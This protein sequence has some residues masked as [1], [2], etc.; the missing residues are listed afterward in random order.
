MSPEKDNAVKRFEES[1][2]SMASFLKTVML[3]SLFVSLLLAVAISIYTVRG[4][5]VSLQKGAEFSALMAKGDFTRRI[6]VTTK[7]EIGIL[8]ASLDVAGQNL[9]NLIRQVVNI[10]DQ[11]AASAEQLNVTADQSAQVVNQMASSVEEM[12]QGAEDQVRSVN[13]AAG[14][15]EEMSSGIHKIASH[16]NIVTEEAGRTSDVAKNGGQ[17]INTAVSQMT[18]IEHTVASSAAVVIK[19]GDRSKEINQIVDTIAGIAGQTNLLALNAAIEAARAGE[20]GRGFAVVAEEVRKLAEQSREAAGKIASLIGEIQGE[21]D[22]AVAAM[23]EGS[24][25]VKVGTEVVN[26][27]GKAFVEIIGAIEHMVGQIRE[28]S[29]AISQMAIG[30]GQIVASVKDINRV[31]KV[32]AAQTQAVLAA[33]E[34]ETASTEELASSSEALA[35][36][37]QDLQIAISRFKISQT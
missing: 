10:S 32:I 8:L 36:L 28:I 14:I 9:C 1:F 26:A 12:A 13:A 22:Q 23:Q 35:K 11:L 17:S 3:I 19:L 29:A 7:D 34:E 16:A 5:S 33:S 27:A 6:E 15:I 24:R 18:N 31:S 20:Q 25:E 37:S 30:T 2:N 4:I 21:T